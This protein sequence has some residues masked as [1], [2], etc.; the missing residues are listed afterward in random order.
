MEA[1]EAFPDMRIES[2]ME[3]NSKQSGPSKMRQHIRIGFEAH[4]SST[5]IISPCWLVF[6][7][8]SWT[9]L[10]PP[11]LCLS[12]K[13]DTKVLFA[14]SV[15]NSTSLYSGAAWYSLHCFVKAFQAVMVGSGLRA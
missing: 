1:L 8:L 7:L 11:P 12:E 3:L 4:H 13:A 15:P 14:Q 2:G 9:L 10:G 5:V 6:S